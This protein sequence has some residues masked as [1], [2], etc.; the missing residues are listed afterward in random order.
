[1]GGG[2]VA[3]ASRRWILDP[4]DGTKSYVRGL[5]TWT[6]L[7]ALQVDGEVTVG[8]VS[9]PA[10]GRRWWAVRGAGAFADGEAIHVSAVTDLSAAQMTW[11]GIEEWDAIGRLD[12]VI[13]LGRACWRSRGIG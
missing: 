5:P 4:I 3:G 1:F 2:G 11:S 7:I 13:A 9:M 8:A 10:Q 12:S 6:T